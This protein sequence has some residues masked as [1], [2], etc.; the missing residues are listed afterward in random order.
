MS[1]CRILPISEEWG[2]ILLIFYGGIVS[3]TVIVVG[4]GN[5]DLCSKPCTGLFHSL[6]ANT[7]QKGMNQSV[8]PQLLPN[9]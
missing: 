2:K 7:P 4:N 9:N 6:R 1:L 8:L 3:F 5:G